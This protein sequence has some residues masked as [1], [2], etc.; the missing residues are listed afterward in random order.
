VLLTGEVVSAHMRQQAEHI[1]WDLKEPPVREVYN[2]VGDR[3][4]QPMSARA[5]MRLLTTKVKA[6][7]FQIQIPISIPPGSKWLRIAVWCI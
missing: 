4:A 3:S 5:T 7:L 2:E 1:A 6:A